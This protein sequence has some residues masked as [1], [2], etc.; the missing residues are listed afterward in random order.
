MNAIAAAKT[1]RQRVNRLARYF[2]KNL[3]KPLLAALR[4]WEKQS[5]PAFVCRRAKIAKG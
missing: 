4:V 1:I 3:L 2:I 5:P